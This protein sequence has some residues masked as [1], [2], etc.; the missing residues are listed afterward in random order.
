MFNRIGNNPSPGV[1]AFI[2]QQVPEVVCWPAWRWWPRRLSFQW[3]GVPFIL[4]IRVCSPIFL[5]PRPGCGCLVQPKAWWRQLVSFIHAALTARR[6]R[7][8]TNG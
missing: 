7:T 3:E 2:A 8:L 1:R 5:A 4:R 6:R